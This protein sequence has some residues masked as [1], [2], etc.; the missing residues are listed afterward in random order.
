MRKAVHRQPQV[1]RSK[2]HSNHLSE[3]IG[4]ALLSS[5]ASE[6]SWYS[7]LRSSCS[8]GFSNV[9]CLRCIDSWTDRNNRKTIICTCTLLLSGQLNVLCTVY[10]YCRSDLKALDRLVRS[11]L[12]QNTNNDSRF[13]CDLQGAQHVA[14]VR[15]RIMKQKSHGMSICSFCQSVCPLFGSVEQNHSRKFRK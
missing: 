2:V 6:D 4:D 8:I 15:E 3:E 12:Q 14:T 10:E 11:P 1:L 7:S 13:R 9:S 5:N